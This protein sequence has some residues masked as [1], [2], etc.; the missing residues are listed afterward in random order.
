MCIR[1]V[2]EGGGASALD[3]YCES[4]ML[5]TTVGGHNAILSHTKPMEFWRHRASTV[6]SLDNLT[7]Q[8]RLSLLPG[9]GLG[10]PSTLHPIICFDSRATRLC[11]PCDILT[12][13]EAPKASGLG[14]LTSRNLVSLGQSK[15]S[16]LAQAASVHERGETQAHRSVS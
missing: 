9:A 14:V 8:V 12:P 5:K 11:P 1:T 16:L 13:S 3:S 10:H 7:L 15:T 6:Y 4:F 2:L